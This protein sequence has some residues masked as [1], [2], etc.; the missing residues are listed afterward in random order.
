[1]KTVFLESHHISNLYFGFGQFNYHLAKNLAATDH[2]DMRFV[3]HAENTGAL[4]AEFGKAFA[5]KKYFSLR[6]YPTFRIRKKYDLWHAMNQN[7]RVEPYHDLPYLL[8]VHDHHRIKDPATYRGQPDHIAF[9]EKLDRSV[10][11]TYISEYTKNS[12]HQNYNVPNVPEYVIYNGNPAEGVAIPSAFRPK[13]APSRP[14]LFTIGVIDPRKNFAS[15]VHMMQELPELDLVIAGKDTNSTGQQVAQLIKDLGLENRITLLGRIS[16][17]EKHWY[18]QNCRGFVFPS[19]REGFGLPVIEAM[20]FG[21]P[22][23]L[24]D[25][26][27]LP[28]IGGDAAHYWTDFEQGYMANVVR[29]GLEHYDNNRDAAA[30]RLITRSKDFSWKKAAQQYYAVYQSILYR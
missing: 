24:S 29:T 13:F 26:T 20:G 21:R 5:Y 15:L 30:G 14:F 4:R 28:E 10:T 19:T 16:D 6:R 9:Q 18:Y 23:F 11:I 8:T 7:T 2:P 12:V 25:K 1:M 17:M 22:V 27:C 3:L